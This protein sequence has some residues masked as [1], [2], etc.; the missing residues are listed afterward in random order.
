MAKDTTSEARG[1]FQPYKKTAGTPTRIGMFVFGCLWSLFGAVGFYSFVMQGYMREISEQGLGLGPK[2]TV[3]VLCGAVVFVAGSILTW[4]LCNYPR[5]I[6]FIIDTEGEMKKVSWPS[7]DDLIRSTLI[8][9]IFIAVFA[10][11]MFGADQLILLV[12]DKAL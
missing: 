2:L 1:F 9:L 5:F 8:V 12:F 6:D 4:W 3:G 11:F 10:G 7:R